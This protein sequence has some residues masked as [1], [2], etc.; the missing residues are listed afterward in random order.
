MIASEKET[1]VV[2]NFRLMADNLR[3][4]MTV[5]FETNPAVTNLEASLGNE[6]LQFNPALRNSQ[7]LWID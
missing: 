4:S 3:D 5:I 2:E 1:H 7:G 6:M